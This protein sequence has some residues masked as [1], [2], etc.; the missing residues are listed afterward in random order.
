[1]KIIRWFF[2]HA[3]LIV[4]IVAVIYSYMYWGNLIGEDTPAGKTLA[5]LSEEFETVDE[6]MLAVRE[7]QAGQESTAV[8]SA[9][10]D[11][12]TIDSAT[13]DSTTI[14]SMATDSVQ[15]DQSAQQ[16]QQLET[17]Q[18][19]TPEVA[20]KE[21]QEDTQEDIREYNQEHTQQEQIGETSGEVPDE[22]GE[23]LAGKTVVAA[24]EP[25]SISYSHNQQRVQ[26]NSEGGYQT[27]TE[28][29]TQAASAEVAQLAADASDGES[30]DV[31]DDLAVQH[32]E[33]AEQ[34]AD[35]AAAAP[36]AADQFVSQEIAEQLDNV[37]DSGRVIDPARTNEM[38]RQEW[39]MARQAFYK[40]DY[41]QS[42]K[43]YLWVIDN[44]KDNVDA[45]GELGNVYFNQGKRQE[46]A[47]AYFDAASILVRRGEKLRARSL[48][49]L[50]RRLDAARAEELQKKLVQEPV[51]S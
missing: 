4:L 30:E 5:Y 10:V 15:H 20:R 6:F 39:I 26:Q 22:S 19:E 32:T 12:T 14:D 42:E 13:V 29:A 17:V 16:G 46:A 8:D 1:M 35:T 48:M 41:E 38:V 50:L 45:Y 51:G 34:S 40:R 31:S 9:A 37:D 27:R 21:V 49:G 18:D 23:D 44:T 2:S 7:K 3:F 25:V 36:A 24:D 47:Q 33:T 28:V 43:S 11:S